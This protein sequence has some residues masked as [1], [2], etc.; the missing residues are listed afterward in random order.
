MNVYVC[1][2][3]HVHAGHPEAARPDVQESGLYGVLSGSLAD[4][5][6]LEQ[7]TQ[8]SQINELSI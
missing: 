8:V 4:S 2:H 5:A 7:C 3:L 1:Q 6:H